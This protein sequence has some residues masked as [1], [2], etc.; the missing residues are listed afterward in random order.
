[1][2]ENSNAAARKAAVRPQSLL[3]LS[4]MIQ[5]TVNGVGFR[6]FIF[7]LARSLG[8][9]GR[10]SNSGQ[11]VMLEVEGRR[12]RLEEFL[13]RIE[14]D[15]PSR[16]FVQSLEWSFLDPVGF[17][18]F[19][20]HNDDSAA[21]MTTLV[22]PD[23]AV[24]SECMCDVFDPANRRH[25]YPFAT[26]SNCGPRFSIIE[27][28]PYNRANT[29]MA[30]FEMCDE[31]RAERENPADRRFHAQS[32]AC[33]VCGPHVELWDATGKPLAI[34]HSAIRQ[35][36]EAIKRSEIV[37]IKGIGGF[38][39]V[40]DASSDTAITRLRRRKQR[41][42]KPFA[43]MCASLSSVQELCE[44]GDLELRVLRSPESP[45]VLLRRRAG[46]RSAISRLVAPGNPYLG[47][48]LPHTPLHLLLM[49]E[50]GF[51]V[52]ATS[53]NLA[54]EPIYTDECDAVARLEGVADWF[55]VHNLPIARQVDDSVVRIVAGREM[56]IRRA[57]GYA[58]L[59]LKMDYSSPSL[60]AVGAHLK[61]AVSTS[62]DRNAF[63]SQHI[64]DLQTPEAFDAFQGAISSLNELCQTEP[65]AVACD[66]HPGYI[67]TQF[68]RE[69]ALPC[70]RVQHHYAH[71]LACMADNRIVTPVLGVAWDGGGYGVDGTIW[72]GE[73]LR[74]TLAA[75][76]PECAYP[77]QSPD[78]P[79][80]RVAHF[81]TFQ[82]PGGERAIKEPR[83]AAV[84]LLYELFGD[85][86]FEMAELAPIRAFNS[87]DLPLIERMLEKRLNSAV[88]SSAGRLF[89]SVAAI[90]GL[91]QRTDFEGQAGRD[92]EFA[93]E[94]VISDDAYDLRLDTS[95][96]Q[97][98][99]IDWEPMIRQLLDDVRAGRPTGLISARF[100]NAMV[101]SIL[102]VA[103]RIGEERV[104][105]TGGC[106][107]N[108]Y[109]IEQAARLLAAEEFR[110]YWHQRVPPNDGGIA[111]GQAVAAALELRR[112]A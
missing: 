74:V 77:A 23:T 102:M 59:P 104:V 82:V 30:R 68:A 52:V 12:E 50:L 56:M 9:T 108:R 20:I 45:I 13:L 51:P 80:Q 27:A 43:L 32:N 1:M 75:T 85:R 3:R 76:Q 103:R 55:L 109:L 8:L 29:T 84:G 97:S 101:N 6:T 15:R 54:D 95:R 53:A 24:C 22:L 93:L 31:C 87:A 90:V 41:E 64:G 83:R 33:P 7:R 47:V 38:H 19:Q 2:S 91:R 26:C 106:L 25:L 81:R 92:L 49:V 63:L 88:T 37:A 70:V 16:S 105:L 40:V 5:G 72:G 86:V 57:R 98:L 36:A 78:Q 79:F 65:I 94:G 4:A 73:F 58:P 14:K 111:L 71:V 21:E 11:G 66:V 62:I 35:A 107:Q 67:S 96:R 48:M 89:D 69:T 34:Y 44:V 28:L 17:E 46:S 61:N 42:E 60:L 99:T 10:V 39:L 112:Q 18:D 100:H 110:P